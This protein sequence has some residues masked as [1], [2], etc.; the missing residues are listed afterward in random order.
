VRIED[1]LLH[2][3]RMQD[4]SLMMPRASARP[5]EMDDRGPG[6]F[7]GRFGT[8]RAS[9]GAG[10]PVILFPFRYWDRWA[11]LADAPEMSYYG[12]A[13]EQPDAYWKRVFWKAEEAGH[14]GLQLGVL[15]RTNLDTPWDAQPEGTNGLEFLWEG[16]LEGDGNPIGV[17]TDR[18]EWR[19]FLRHLPGSFD[20]TAG[21]AHGWKTTARLEL[22]GVEY[23]GPN[24]TLARVDR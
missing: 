20:A 24:R 5:G 3:V 7:R 11:E 17:Q 12:L 19:V 9:H 23:M 18:V 15:Q 10:A 1:E 2:Y 4:G 21:L 22:F 8:E 16:K 6:L 14:P 13:C